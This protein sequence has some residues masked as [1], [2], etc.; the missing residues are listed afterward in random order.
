V[1]PQERIVTLRET[2]K[3][4][5]K[6]RVL[7]C[8]VDKDGNK[9]CE[10]QAVDGGEKLT[11][12][13]RRFGEGAP[14]NGARAPVTHVYHW[15]TSEPPKGAPVA[16]ATAIVVGTAVAAPKAA[17]ASAPKSPPPVAPTP[18]MEQGTITLKATAD[19]P[20][21]KC[22]LLKEYNDKDGNKVSQL[23]VISTGQIMT[24]VEPGAGS[25]SKK[26]TGGLFGWGS[27]EKKETMPPVMTSTGPLL[28]KAP[29]PGMPEQAHER[30][31]SV[32][33]AGGKLALKC[34][35]LKEWIESDGSKACQLQAIETGEMLTMRETRQGPGMKP[36]AARVFHWGTSSKPPK[37]AP[38]PPP[39]A[40]AVAKPAPAPAPKPSL[41]SRLFGSSHS[42][43]TTSKTTTKPSTSA[44]SSAS[45]S[46]V[47]TDAKPP[48]DWQQSWGKVESWKTDEAKKPEG[49]A[50]RVETTAPPGLLTSA[51]AAPVM[52]PPAG[53]QLAPQPMPVAPPPSPVIVQKPAPVV[54]QQFVRMESTS[55]PTLPMAETTKT[56]PLSQPQG[57]VKTTVPGMPPVMSEPPMAGP[58][59]PAASTSVGEKAAA[60]TNMPPLPPPS[61][62]PTVNSRT[63]APSSSSTVISSTIISSEKVSPSPMMPASPSPMMPASRMTYIASP[64]KPSRPSLWGLITGRQP[65]EPEPVHMTEPVKVVTKPAQ[66]LSAAEKV[67]D[68]E[69]AAP[70]ANVPMGMGSVMAAGSPVLNRPPQRIGEMT[71]VDGEPVMKPVGTPRTPGMV[72]IPVTTPN[73]FTVAAGS[74]GPM[75]MPMM[76]PPGPMMMPAGPMMPPGSMMAQAPSGMGNAFTTAGTSRPIPADYGMAAN[77]P[78]AFEHG[79]MSPAPGR[80]PMAMMPPPG[81]YPYPMPMPRMP[82]APPTAMAQAPVQEPQTRQLIAVLHSSV[83]PSER[84]MAVDQLTCFDWRSQPQVAAAIV[85]AA[86]NDPSATVRASCV[87]AMAKMKMNTLPAVQTVQALKNDKDIR[88]RQEVEQALAIMSH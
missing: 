28:V 20:E 50:Y 56:D 79:G 17:P 87:R 53:V 86:K 43:S 54:Q 75:P 25:A 51:Q 39:D 48:K 29:V 71:V 1:L 14:P 73:A 6:C 76:V 44:S 88:V 23:Q 68:K 47:K 35:V 10:V 2:G 9:V 31:V 61:F 55:R 22:R 42:D 46:V 80:P 4:A 37:G 13:E 45:T 82:M 5:M 69:P 24:T 49:P 57:F 65:A 11:I 70:K 36:G 27:S 78:N 59:K 38:I 7:K 16:P 30:V 67:T 12:V 40:V 63:M 21:L 19:H 52:Q 34:R 8:W 60:T 74:S 32:R 84:E 64:E 58:A 83:M 81:Y 33:E 18:T 66:P 85:E 3:P 15:Q 77:D 41:M 26:S 72:S 62:A